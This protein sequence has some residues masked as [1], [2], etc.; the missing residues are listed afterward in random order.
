[1][2][3]W[4]TWMVVPGLAIWAQLFLG[5][6]VAELQFADM[7]LAY[8]AMYA[9]P[10]FVLNAGYWS[11]RIAVMQ[12]GFLAS[13]L[14]GLLILPEAD[15]LGFED[16]LAVLWLCGLVTV[17]LVLGTDRFAGRTAEE[18]HEQEGVG[19]RIVGDGSVAEDSE[20]RR[21]AVA[22]S[23]SYRR[24]FT[25]RLAVALWLFAVITY[26]VFFDAGVQQAVGEYFAGG[27]LVAVSFLAVLMFFVWCMVVYLMILVPAMNLEYDQR[28]LQQA[29]AAMSQVRE[30][31]AAWLRV[32]MW[33]SLSGVIGLAMFFLR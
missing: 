7:R 18:E 22:L 20:R 11:G 1:M 15:R 23:Q 9:L 33:T 31:R 2:S 8:L 27:E 10:L 26:A 25:V 30:R 14:P 3:K 16:P 24:H 6:I 29:I 28:R 32:L 19:Q 5:A 17:Y 12:V 13:L 21:N 4:S